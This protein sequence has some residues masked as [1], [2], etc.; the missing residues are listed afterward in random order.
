MPGQAPSPGRAA[1]RFITFEGGE[2]TGKSTQ[3]RLLARHLE[4]AGHRVT[5]TREP[6]GT[7]MAEHI[8]SLLLMRGEAPFDPLAETLMHFAARADHL[9]HCI[10]PALADGRIVLCDRF[11]DST[12]AYQGAGHGVSLA[13]IDALDKMVTGATQP[14]LTLLL[15]VPPAVSRQR[16]AARDGAGGGDRYEV[17]ADAFHA[18][19]A[20]GFSD[21]PARFPDRVARIDGSGTPEDVAARIAA[22]VAER[23]AI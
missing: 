17:L 22:V 2:G 16:R 13:R 9:A 21:L 5:V 3:I 23:L 6:G 12:R 14:D 4:G 20:Q 11:T 7:V 8:R 1:G 15:D 10:R 18:R 19:V